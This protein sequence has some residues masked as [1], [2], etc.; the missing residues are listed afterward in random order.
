MWISVKDRLPPI[1]SETRQDFLAAW[2]DDEG[3]IDGIEWYSWNGEKWYFW[4]LNSNNRNEL[5]GRIP[6]F[7]YWMLVPP[8]EP[9]KEQP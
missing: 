6:M 3:S 7:D 1:F 2:C 9:P 8:L 4:N 5:G